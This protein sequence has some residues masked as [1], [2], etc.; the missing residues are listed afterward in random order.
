MST[1]YVNRIHLTDMKKLISFKQIR[2]NYTVKKNL[3]WD[4]A[5][6]GFPRLIR[7]ELDFYPADIHPVVT[8]KLSINWIWIQLEPDLNPHYCGWKSSSNR[9]GIQN[10]IAFQ[11]GLDDSPLDINPALSVLGGEI[12]LDLDQHPRYLLEWITIQYFEIIGLH[13]RGVATP[14]PP[15]SSTLNSSLA[16][17]LP[18]L[19]W[20]TPTREL[21]RKPLNM[22]IK[23][24]YVSY[25]LIVLSQLSYSSLYYF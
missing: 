18:H 6:A 3:D 12:R 7:I 15:P 1:N 5:Q 9:M 21:N 13:Y 19:R 10:W 17:A 8:G 2:K 20:V 14:L 4:P 25:V 22:V 24:L 11:M 16:C 23:Y